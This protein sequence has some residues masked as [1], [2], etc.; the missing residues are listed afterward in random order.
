MLLALTLTDYVLFDRMDIEFGE[1]LNVVSG[2][3]GA[4]KSILLGALELLLGG[5]ADVSMIRAGEERAVVEGLFRI[6][7][8]IC[9]RLSDAG[10]EKCDPGGE[11]VLRREISGSGRSRCYVNG[12]MANLQM[13]RSLGEE[14]VE[15]HGQA[16][17]R[18]LVRPAHQ[19]DLLD[20]F[21]GLDARRADFTRLLA[22]S[23]AAR[24]RL[25]ELEKSLEKFRNEQE[26]IRFQLQ[27]IDSAAPRTE[28]EEELRDGI[29]LLENSEKIAGI[30][31]FTLQTLDGDPGVSWIGGESSAP[32]I[33]S[34]RVLNRRMEQLAGLLQKARPIAEQIDSARFTL[35]EAARSLRDIALSLEHDPDRLSELRARSDLL[36]MLKKKYGPAL[37]DVLAHRERIAARLDGAERDESGIEALRIE[38]GNLETSVREA[39]AGLSAARREAAARMEGEVKARLEGLSMSGAGFR[40]EFETASDGDGN[41]ACLTTGIDRIN[42]LLSTNPGVPLMPLSRVASGGELSRVMLAIKSALAQVESPSTMV[43]DE[44]DSGI[45]GRVGGTVGEYLARIAERHQVLVVTHLAQI[46]RC[47]SDHLVVEKTE[48]DGRSEISVRRLRDEDRPHEIARMMGG[49]AGSSLSLAHAREMLEKP[50]RKDGR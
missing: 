35:E 29:S 26:L 41:P 33:E 11:L 34:L 3:T 5:E 28:E 16:D 42:F 44:V 39:A 10:I 31:D 46:A 47:A 15:I 49:D 8:A 12:A 9:G 37:E 13:L 27:E 23:R 25:E 14:L 50:E 22:S 4:G 40:V 19:L 18:L 6:T 38:C 2:E 32:V 48:R 45:G 20:A 36:Y 30:L 1:H 24:R 17:N 21:G 43:F 7:S